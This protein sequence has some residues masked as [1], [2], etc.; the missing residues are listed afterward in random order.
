MMIDPLHVLD[1]IRSVAKEEILP[2]YQRL[3]DHE[4]S[5]KAPGD[6]VTIADIEAERRLTEEFKALLTG[7]TVVG[8]EGVANNPDSIGALDH[9]GAVWIVDPVDGT[10]NF[11]DGKPCFAVMAALCIDRQP[12]AA[13]IYDPLGETAIYALTEQGAFEGGKRLRMAAPTDIGDMTGS[14]NRRITSDLNQR[15]ASGEIGVPKLVKRYRCVGREYMDLARGKLHF[16]Q[17][18]GNLKPWDHVPGVLIHR[19][20]G[21]YDAMT[22]NNKKYEI[23]AI[24]SNKNIMLAPSHN[25]WNKLTH[26]LGK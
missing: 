10:Q 14:L 9:D 18:G 11:A 17:Y 20:I 16:L 24:L 26:F 13:W 15:R 12:K 23:S 1:I 22:D 4:I 8:E 6:L 2:R 19:E 5:E 21:G 25:I 3:A 7:S